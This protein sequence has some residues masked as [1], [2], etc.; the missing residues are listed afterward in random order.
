MAKG[1]E[2]TAFYRWLRLVGPERGRR[3][4]G[5]LRRHAGRAPRRGAQAQVTS[6]PL[7]MTTLSTHDTKRAEDVRARLR[8]ARRA[9]ARAGRPGSATARGA[10]RRPPRR[11]ASTAAP[12]TCSGRPWSATWPIDRA[13]GSRSTCP[14]RS[15]RRSCTRPGPTP[16]EAYEGAV[17]RASPRRCSRDPR[18]RSGTS[19]AWTAAHDAVG[20]GDVLGQ[21]LVQL[22][23]PG[24]PDVYQG[25]E[26]VDLSLVDPDN[27]RPVD[28]T[29]RWRAAR[30]VLDDGPARAT[31][32]TRSCWSPLAALR[33]R[34]DAARV[35]VGPGTGVP[36]LPTVE[37]A[38]ARLRARRRRRAPRGRRRG[39]PCG[40]AASR[41]AGAAATPP[42]RCPTAPG[43]TCSPTR[44]GP[45]RRAGAPRRPAGAPA[46]G[47][48]ARASAEATERRAPLASGRRAP[49]ASTSTSMPSGGGR[50][51]TPMTADG[52]G[53]GG[54]ATRPAGTGDRLRASARRRD[55]PRRTRAA[56]GSR[57]ACTGRAASST[58]RRYRWTDDGWRGP[59]GGAGA[60]A[61]DLR[62]ARR[63][64]HRRRARSTLRWPGSTTSSTLGVD[65][66]ELMPVAAVPRP[67]RLGLRR[68]RACTRCTSRTAGRPRC[69]AFVDAVPRARARRLPRRR[70]QP[71][72]RPAGNYLARVRPVL[73]RRAPDAR[74]VPR[75]TSTAPGCRRG[76]P[77]G[78]RQRAAL[79]PRLPRRRAAA[80][81]RARAA[82]T[83]ARRTSW[84]SC[85][86]RS[87]RCRAT[88]GRPLD[89]V[90]E[91]R[92]QRPRHR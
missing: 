88:L 14:R 55:P 2:D 46:A 17:R 36:P 54:P 49:R 79:V 67:L 84:R 90:A 23:L 70:L 51:P 74:G 41:R 87:P 72:R 40:R 38:R 11:P 18:R 78:H 26:V 39:D 68:R 58:R 85:P 12:S 3:R 1:V 33:L 32:T 24:V 63:H 64:V 22:T 15:A 76:A 86:T 52:D 7:A 9:A 56:P 69:S 81:R 50:R 48:P 6:W 37:R 8:G 13:T 34:R 29:D 77:L 31:S 25:R 65:L 10:R 47:R 20:A 91:S 30:P 21:K 92:P 59:R 43:A 57:T 66:V 44:A 82:S 4:P 89:L 5:P 62:A 60:S 42:S 27:R 73:H 71:P 75:S 35:F 45:R 16:D 28:W 53:G 19:T 61:R 80:G 83:T